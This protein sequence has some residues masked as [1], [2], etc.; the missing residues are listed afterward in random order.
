M[1]RFAVTYRNTQTNREHTLIVFAE[2][3]D[4][5]I[6]NEQAANARMSKWLPPLEIVSVVAK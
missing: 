5:A 6:Q 2:S 4:Q 1:T 3:K